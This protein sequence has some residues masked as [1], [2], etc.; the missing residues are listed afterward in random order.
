[1]D[2]DLRRA[3]ATKLEWQRYLLMEGQRFGRELP[4]EGSGVE[5]PPGSRALEAFTSPNGSP[6]PLPFFMDDSFMSLPLPAMSCKKPLTHSITM[7]RLK[8]RGFRSP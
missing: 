3:V 2:D 4:A 8:H 7:W 6:S 1:V 5:L